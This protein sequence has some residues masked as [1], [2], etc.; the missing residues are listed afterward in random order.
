MSE[1]KIDKD[2]VGQD[3]AGL[4]ALLYKRDKAPFQVKQLCKYSGWYSQFDILTHE[5]NHRRFFTLKLK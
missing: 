4:L 1:P 2:E 3:I 5:W